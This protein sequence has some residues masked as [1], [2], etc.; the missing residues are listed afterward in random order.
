MTLQSRVFTGEEGFVSFKEAEGPWNNTADAVNTSNQVAGT[1]SWQINLT[2]DVFDT[3]HLG[4]K[5]GKVSGGILRGTGT[6]D[7]I[8]TVHHDI[9]DTLNDQIFADDPISNRFSLFWNR[10]LK[11]NADAD[12]FGVTDSDVVGLQYSGLRNGLT[13]PVGRIKSYEITFDGLVNNVE[14][15]SNLGEIAVVRLAFSTDGQI[16]FRPDY[17]S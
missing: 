6:V 3:T 2:R 17:K 12:D 15:V 5:Y 8:F 9:T 10:N 1:K 13:G 7:A 4:D 16:E 14:F 11:A